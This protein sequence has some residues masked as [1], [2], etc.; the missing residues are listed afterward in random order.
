[1]SLTAVVYGHDTTWAPPG[2]WIDLVEVHGQPG[3]LVESDDPG[4]CS[5]ALALG[6]RYLACMDRQNV[7]LAYCDGI[8]P[9]RCSVRRDLLAALDAA[10]NGT[11]AQRDA[12][13]DA[14]LAS[15]RD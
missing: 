10:R 4:L 9:G 6:P 5:A 8:D 3:A 14:L 2:A 11:H 13:L 12:A 1:M 15:V 7:V